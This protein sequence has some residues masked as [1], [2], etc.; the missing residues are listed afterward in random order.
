M[1]LRFRIH[2]IAQ[3]LVFLHQPYL[4]RHTAQE[5]PQFFERGKRLRNVVVGAQFHS[6]YRGFHRAVA[7]HDRDLGAGQHLLHLLEELEA[8]HVR[9]HHVSED[10]VSRLLL[11]DGEGGFP[12]GRLKTHKAQSLSYGDAQ[13][14]NAL[15]VIDNQQTDT[16]VFTHSAFPMVFSTTEINCAT[17]KGFSTQGAPV[18]RSVLT[19]FSLAMSPVINTSRDVRSGRLAS[20]QAYTSAP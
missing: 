20:I 5:Q 19:V 18:W 14:A 3:E 6:L 1:Q 16:K 10:H 15:F 12:A 7:G 13:T 2:A 17:R 9:H 11:Q 4:F 8:R